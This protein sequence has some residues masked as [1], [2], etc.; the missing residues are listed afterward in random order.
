MAHTKIVGQ[1][2][3]CPYALG[4]C[5]EADGYS[6]SVAAKVP[7]LLPYHTFQLVRQ[8]VVIAAVVLRLFSLS[9]HNCISFCDKLFYIIILEF[10]RFL[11]INVLQAEG[12][13]CKQEQ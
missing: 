11:R 12:S 2:P 8:A 13:C 9:Y 7:K 10:R 4:V 5:G 6:G 3:F 1:G